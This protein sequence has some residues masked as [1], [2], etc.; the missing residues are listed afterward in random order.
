MRVD[1]TGRGW[2]TWTASRAYDPHAFEE[3]NGQPFT[4]TCNSSQSADQCGSPTLSGVRRVHDPH[5][6]VNGTRYFS[7]MQF[8]GRHVKVTRFIYTPQ[9]G[10]F[11]RPEPRALTSQGPCTSPKPR[12]AHAGRLPSC[13]DACVYVP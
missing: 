3:F 1:V 11:P 12:C 8:R 2:T 6:L 13:E 7:R 4:P 10:W 5:Y 9:R